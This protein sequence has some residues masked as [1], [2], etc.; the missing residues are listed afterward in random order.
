MSPEEKLAIYMDTVARTLD[1][2][3]TETLKRIVARHRQLL[4][5]RGYLR[6][7]D[8]INSRWTWTDA[9]ANNFYQ[10]K[11]YKDALAEAEKVKR[12]F[13]AIMK[14]DALREA[15]LQGAAYSLTYK[16][17]HREMH[18]QLK[19][20]NENAKVNTI[21]MEMSVKAISDIVRPE[22][23]DVPDTESTAKFAAY[24]KS[25][26]VK[27][28]PP[29]AAPG[30]SDHG[31]FQAFDFKVT[32]DGKVIADTKTKTIE[33]KWDKAGWTDRLNRAVQQSE[34][35]L[36]GPLPSPYEPWHYAY[37]ET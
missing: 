3:V 16:R 24:V 35:T 28:D 19:N 31:R 13:E 29:L 30:L 21:A 25:F 11:E 37:D 18:E 33:D 7:Q 23:P 22:Y 5:L 14:I 12:Q 9:E 17:T 6:R 27:S 10:T 20:W 34:A 32:R 1:S 15:A 26:K 2:R 36:S 8:L 4:A